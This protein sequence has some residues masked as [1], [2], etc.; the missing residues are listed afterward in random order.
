MASST[1]TDWIE[2]PSNTSF[3]T[4]RWTP[5]TEPK[6]HVVFVHGFV[7]YIERYDYFF[8]QFANRGVSVFSYDQRGFGRTGQKTDTFGV[9]DT[10]K[11]LADMEFFL[12]KE[13][14]RLKGS[15]VPIFLFGHSMGGGEVLTYSCLKDDHRPT[16]ASLSGVVASAPLIS[17][18]PSKK[19]SSALLFVGG[20]IG[21]V[22]PS[23]QMKLAALDGG[24]THDEEL[25]AKYKEDPLCAPIGTYRGVSNM[26]NY[27]Q[28]LLD[29]N[30]ATF[31]AKLPLLVYHGDEDP[32]T[33][34]EASK[35][36]V[37]KVKADDK[38]F[39]SY[40]GYFHEL[41]N[42]PGEM[43]ER[44][45]EDVTAWILKRAETRARL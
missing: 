33:Y 15:G 11:Q 41:H 13:E 5:S 10:V 20:L 12:A 22:L 6:A 39:K 28:A 31:P 14:Q 8:E 1:S 25:N 42:E 34:H 19:A 30:Y 4:K 32:I 26:L 23:L 3:F 37:E 16:L 2:G 27:G 24:L 17:Q 40:K 45:I 18:I 38:E 44:I 9:T 36:F 7:E 35:E 43:K 21:K 29:K